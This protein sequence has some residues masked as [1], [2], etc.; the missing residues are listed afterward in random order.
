MKRS[1]S[2]SRSRRISKRFHGTPHE[3]GAITGTPVITLL[4]LRFFSSALSYF[5]HR[6][7]NGNKLALSRDGSHGSVNKNK[8]GKC[9]LRRV[10][11]EKGKDGIARADK[12][13]KRGTT[14]RARE[15]TRPEDAPAPSDPEIAERR[16][17]RR[18]FRESAFES[19]AALFLFR[20]RRGAELKDP[21]VIK[22]VRN[23][24]RS[25]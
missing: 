21:R 25:Q 20:P 15:I 6:R 2:T 23:A 18:R 9:S 17:R 14:Q 1:V 8:R 10:G 24:P 11:R 5:P 16:R 22:G 19:R 12:R 4:Q 7:Y 13:L 3:R